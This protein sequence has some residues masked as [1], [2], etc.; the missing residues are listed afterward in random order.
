M[1][2]GAMPV[3]LDQRVGGSLV[4]NLVGAMSGHSRARRASFLLGREE[5]GCS[6]A[7]SHRR[8]SAARARPAFAPV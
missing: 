8:R 3:V 2:S 1:K 4:G 6:T 5:E 7:R